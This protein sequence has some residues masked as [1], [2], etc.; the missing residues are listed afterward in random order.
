MISPLAARLSHWYGTA[1]VSKR[2]T[3]KAT[4]CLRARY[5]TSTPILLRLGKKW[6]RALT[7]GVFKGLAQSELSVGGQVSP[8]DA[9]PE[10]EMAPMAT[11]AAP[12]PVEDDQHRQQ[13]QQ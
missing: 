4:A 7:R 3:G 2:L 11:W 9:P 13:Q 5:R 10:E 8:A 6:Y 12:A 1:R